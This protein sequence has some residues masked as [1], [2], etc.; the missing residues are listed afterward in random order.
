M[1]YLQRVQ[2]GID[3][4]EA[5]LQTEIDAHA[6]AEAAGLSQWHFQRI[7]K[8]LTNETLK[9]YIRSRRFAKA[10]DQLLHSQL[11]ILDI[12]LASGFETQ[13]SFTRAFK[14]CFHI[15]PNHYRRFGHRTQF[16]KKL[17]ID[18]NYMRHLHSNVSLAPEVCAQEPMRLVGMRTQFFGVDSE[19]NNLGK[20]LPPLWA[21]FISRLGEVPHTVPGTCYGVVNAL[22]PLGDELEY[23]AAI[24]VTKI[25]ALPSGMVSLEIDG[26]TYARF[27]HRGFAHAIDHTVNYIYSNW[28]AASGREHT[29]GPDL[30][31]YGAGFDPSSASSVMHYAVPV[32]GAAS[33][34][35]WPEQRERD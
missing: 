1:F 10:L 2:R 3:F 15:T 16:V 30:E 31:I 18:E 22:R 23:H 35:G 28:M 7:F 4:I 14:T 12:A 6:V 32:T 20:R 33:H 11:P 19:K 25:G 9:T 8:A 34:G 29:S 27:C 13:A 24:A 21:A 26:A 17:H 5:H